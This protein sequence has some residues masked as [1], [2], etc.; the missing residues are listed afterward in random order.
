MLEKRVAKRKLAEFDQPDKM[1]K[2]YERPELA[3]KPRQEAHRLVSQR[4]RSV[5][6]VCS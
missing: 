1:E 4:K 2:I 5:C 3:T 6:M